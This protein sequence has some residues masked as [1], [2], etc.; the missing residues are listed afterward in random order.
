MKVLALGCG[1]IGSVAVEDLAESVPSVEIA[2]ADKDAA[3]AKTVAKKIRRNN[4]SAIQL[5]VTNHDKLVSA[6][7]SYDL[8][9]GFLPGK[10]GYGLIE[11]CIDAERNLVDVSYMAENPLKL[12]AKA[13]RAR[14]TIVPDCGLAPGI[15]NFLIGH[16]VAK[17]DKVKAV[18]IM[19]GGLPEE[20]VAPLGYTITWSPESLIDEYTR[21]SAIVREGRRIEVEALTGL[22]EVNFPKF[23][24]LEAFYTD[25]LRTLLNTVENVEDMWEKTLRYPGHAEKIKLLEALGFFTE[26]KVNV[27]GANVSP[28]KL[29]VSLFQEKLWRPEI[30]DIVALKVEVAGTKDGKKA[31]YAYHLLD[32]FDEKHE[33]TAMARTTAYPMSIVA[34]MV[35]KQ[36]VREN[37]VV[38]PEKL[39]MDDELFKLFSNGLAQRGIKVREEEK[40]A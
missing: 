2:V 23:G 10:L 25:G 11:A 40:T 1:N 19:V 33:I 29:T 8:A 36:A 34:Q 24:K 5:D 22:E 28:R 16:A 9:I 27:E 17:L 15:S 31:A 38:P 37:G 39:G 13:V 6:L 7:K 18:H 20:P 3:R 32:F 35:L 12:N 4:V 21:K 14:V 26:R 30:K